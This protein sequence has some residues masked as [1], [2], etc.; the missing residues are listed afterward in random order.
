VGIIFIN[1]LDVIFKQVL[2][3][4]YI[5]VF[6]QLVWDFLRMLHL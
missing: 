5:V 6:V 2:W 1:C 4:W 3:T